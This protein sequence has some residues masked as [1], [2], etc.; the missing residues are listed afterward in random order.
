MKTVHLKLTPYSS[1]KNSPRLKEGESDYNA[2][3]IELD[4]ADMKLAFF[5]KGTIQFLKLKTTKDFL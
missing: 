4:G 2:F 1:Q 3:N 5:S